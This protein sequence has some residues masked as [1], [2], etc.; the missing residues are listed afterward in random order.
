[1]DVRTAAAGHALTEEEVAP[2]DDGPHTY[3]S[4][5]STLRD[6]AGKPYAIFGI[7]TDITELKVVEEN[8]RKSFKE[9][10]DYKFE[11]D[12]SSIVAI[13]DQK[14]II[15]YAND[16]FCKISKYSREELIGQDH[17]IINSGYHPKDFIRNLWVTIANGKIWKGELKNKAKDGTIYWVDTTIIPF[18]NLEGKPYQYVAIRADITGRKFAE[19]QTKESEERFRLLVENV[20]DYGIFM[21]DT[22]GNIASWN[23]GAEYIKGYTA[24]EIIGKPISVFYTQDEIEKGEP[25]EN[26]RLAKE[27]GHF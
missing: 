1:M 21:V 7:S 19:E 5:K 12:E 9:I 15:K 13:T 25:E 6:N 8:L 26:L 24:K 2:H 11:L 18:L 16:N 10:S 20:R 14:G 3:I 22:N 27:K 17:R 4:V 23:K